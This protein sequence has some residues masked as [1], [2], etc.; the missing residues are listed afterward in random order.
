MIV[1]SGS[2][3]TAR[4]EVQD[5]G[6]RHPDDRRAERREGGAQLADALA[7]GAPAPADVHRAGDLQDVAAVEGPWRLDPV[8]RE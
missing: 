2:A 1:P 5:L 4:L 8:R 3:V 6:Q 7:V